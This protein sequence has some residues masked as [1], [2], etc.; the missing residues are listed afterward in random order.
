MSRDV[1]VLVGMRFRCG[2]AL[3][4]TKSGGIC[5]VGEIVL[6][7]RVE[8]V[9]KF[10]WKPAVFLRHPDGTESCGSLEY[11]TTVYKQVDMFDDVEIE[12]VDQKQISETAM[13]FH[14][15]S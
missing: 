2:N 8:S 7:E 10:Q 9:E 12:S 14:D 1:D 13:V 6:V 15:A 11:F 3:W 4:V 5:N